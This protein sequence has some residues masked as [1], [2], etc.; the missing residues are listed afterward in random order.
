MERTSTVKKG[1]VENKISLLTATRIC[2]FDFS[3]LFGLSKK[4]NPSASAMENSIGS[5]KF[6]R[7]P[8]LHGFESPDRIVRAY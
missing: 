8:T 6:I 5:V 7:I 1:F 2:Y 3:R 4:G